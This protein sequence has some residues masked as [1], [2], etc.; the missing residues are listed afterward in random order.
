MTLAKDE[1]GKRN[2][3]DSLSRARVKSRILEGA[4]KMSEGTAHISELGDDDSEKR[5]FSV[6]LSRQFRTVCFVCTLLAGP[7]FQTRFRETFSQAGRETRCCGD[8][9]SRMAGG[10]VTRK[11]QR[12]GKC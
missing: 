12:R 1:E 10:G 2:K 11:W 5:K 8:A 7:R 3:G 4:W 6:G 9:V